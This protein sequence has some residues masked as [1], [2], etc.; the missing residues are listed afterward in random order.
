MTI[1]PDSRKHHY[2]N[3]LWLGLLTGTLDAIAALIWSRKINPSGI[4]KYIASGAFGKAAFTNGD[5][6]VVWGVLFH[7]LIAYS[8]TVFFYVMH[9]Y[10][11][12]GLKNK[13]LVAIVYALITWLVTNLLI[14]PLSCIG[15][16]SM[17]IQSIIIGFVILIFTIGLPIVLVANRVYFRRNNNY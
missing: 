16:H 17:S 13:Y 3:I 2:A 12:A 8:V 15:W 5:N 4:F 10:F 9:P 14:V 1:I 7:Y 11:V 6:M